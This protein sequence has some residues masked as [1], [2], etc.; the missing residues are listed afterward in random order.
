M[1]MTFSRGPKRS[2]FRIFIFI[3]EVSVN[4][5]IF[6][7]RETCQ[8]VIS[9]LNDNASTAWL[10]NQSFHDLLIIYTTCV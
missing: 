10:F 9:L 2:R 5:V 6:L 3:F 4:Q 1:D 7:W 8:R